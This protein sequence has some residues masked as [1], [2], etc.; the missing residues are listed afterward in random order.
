MYICKSSSTDDLEPL[1][2]LIAPMAIIP[3][4]KINHIKWEL[5]LRKST[6]KPIYNKYIYI[7]IGCTWGLLALVCVLKVKKKKVSILQKDFITQDKNEILSNKRREALH[8]WP[9][10]I[11]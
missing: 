7:Y 10:Q 3:K 1:T 2:T 4:P 8:W 6:S 11:P 5:N 9:S